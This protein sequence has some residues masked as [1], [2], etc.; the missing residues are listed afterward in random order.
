MG[1][2]EMKNTS[3]QKEKRIA[4]LERALVI[5][6]A[7]ER[8][9]S[10]SMAMRK[11]EELTKVATIMSD[12]FQK[13]GLTQSASAGFGLID[14]EKEVQ[15]MWGS[16][17][18]N[19]LNYFTMPL[20]GD[21]VLQDRY[22]AWKRQDDFFEQILNG[23]ELRKHLEVA[24]P[25]TETTKEEEVSKSS[26]PDPSYFYFANF[27]QGYLQILSGKSMEEEYE[28]ILKR[29]AK[30]F[31]QTYTRFLDL[32]KAENQALRLQE[33]D[34]TKTTFYTNI[35]HEFRTPL[36][37]ILGMTDQL[38]SHVYESGREGLEMIDRNGK[39][40]LRLVNQMLDLQKLE[41][42]SMS[43]DLIQGDMLIYLRY[44]VES[45]HSYAATKNIRIYFLTELEQ[46]QMD[47]DPD[48]LQSIVSNLLSNAVKFTPKGGEVFV[49]LKLQTQHV[50]LCIRDTG[51]GIK[52]DKIP[53]IFDRFYQVEGSSTRSAEGTGIG[54]ALTKEL[55]H[56]LKGVIS[57]NSQAGQGAEFV[58]HLP[59]TRT[60]EL[61]E[62]QPLASIISPTVIPQPEYSDD[63]LAS[64][65]PKNNLLIIEDNVDVVHYLSAC[66]SNH[67]HLDVAYNGQE[68]IEKALE[69]IPDLIISDVMMPL[70]DGLEVCD[71]LKNDSRTSHIPILLLTAKVDLEARLQGIRQGA[72]AYLAKPFKTDELLAHLEAL[73]QQRNRI[74]EYYLHLYGISN[75]AK[76][77]SP[78]IR[79]NNES[80][81]IIKVKEQIQANMDNPNFGVDQLSD[82]LAIS[83]TQLYRKIK[84]QTGRTT[85]DLIRSIRLHHAQHLLKNAELSIAEIAYETGFSEPGYFSKVFKKE[86]GVI[87]TEYKTQLDSSK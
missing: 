9:R 35:T 21:Q 87:P 72:D 38:K 68:G 24:M 33:L 3:Q 77:P 12:E 4:Q 65:V 43:L 42:K 5:E 79:I 57:V 82:F 61:V 66:L 15:Y 39:Q 19:L 83:S 34:D 78:D 64:I 48:K 40:L 20:F 69:T 17:S 76:L 58:I 18:D 23:P 63:S 1:S 2:E 49:E 10:A 36:T 80:D 27:K 59:I 32:Q 50:I 46:L 52:A 25:V 13:L 47:Y 29:F 56:L 8:V 14:E 45:F 6:T 30:V 67:Y 41:S 74:Q 26:M 54:L 22:D 73:W 28:S 84:A 37:I 53:H 71:S 16:Q 81:F 70:K 86:F 51:I 31:E 75:D 60:A 85:H 55:V 7:L 62:E 44:L 11:S